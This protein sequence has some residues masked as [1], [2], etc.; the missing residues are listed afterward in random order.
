VPVIDRTAETRAVSL[1]ESQA[2]R[3]QRALG[4]LA[5]LACVAVVSAAYLAGAF[6]AFDLRL[7][8]WR[9]RIRGER[10]AEDQIAIVAIDDATIHA[11]GGW[12]LPRD[13]YALLIQA[14]EDAGARAIG[15][16]LQLPEDANHDPHHNALLAYVTSEHAN[17]VHAVSFQAAPAAGGETI[18]TPVAGLDALRRQGLV[19][20]SMALPVAATALMP[21][22]ELL[23]QAGALGHITVAAD[24]D[25][26]IRRQPPLVRYED[27]VYASMALRMVGVGT[28]HAGLPSMVSVPGGVRVGWKGGPSWRLPLDAEGSTA[29]DFA[30]DRRAFPHAYSMIEVLRDY[31]QERSARLRERFAG[32]FVMIGLDSQTEVTEDVGTTPFSAATPLVFIHANA[33]DNFLRGRFLRHAPVWAYLATLTALALGLGWACAVLPMAVAALVA[34]GSA[35]AFAAVDVALLRMFGLDVP[36]FAMLLTVPAVYAAVTSGRFLFLESRSRMREE[37]IRAGRS[38]EQQFLPEAL[39]GH[40]LGR[41]RVVDKLGSGAMGIVYR[42]RDARLERDVAIKVL[43]ARALADE[44]TRRRFR[45][46]ALALSRLNH[47]HIA[48][49]FDFDSQD[50]TDYLVMEYVEGVAL[51]ERVRRG[52]MPE[53]EVVRI[54]GEVAAALVEAHGRGVIHRD[55]KPENVRLTRAGETKVLDFGIARFLDN[56]ATSSTRSQNLTE[57][58]H[59]VG[60]LPYMAPEVLRGEPAEFRSDLYSLGVMAFEMATGRRPFPNDEPHELMYT[61][62]NQAPPEPRILNGRLSSRLEAIIL[63]LLAKA[64]EARF[65][66]AA[67]LIEA[68]RALETSPA[69]A[70]TS[71]ARAAH[72]EATDG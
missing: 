66:S 22:R 25:G 35:L 64:P 8:D 60:T 33:I 38:V 43:P 56:E 23:E 37:D 59:M 52:A 5:A 34:L 7:L 13:Q 28:G 44:K 54:V 29:L 42:G 41:Y 10:A 30:G 49:I 2:S 27:R 45:R 20:A 69:P 31:Q 14:L 9:F 47:R 50:G 16:D 11:F 70:A 19:D 55:L 46:E 53:P 51:G 63:R 65:A 48:S 40:D 71:S 24:R 58:G 15:V 1:T 26:A 67:E 12:P 61:V 68:L 72:E 39:I 18:T 62:L 3:R 21:Y 6:Q 57:V 36:P 17:I 32:R 4:P